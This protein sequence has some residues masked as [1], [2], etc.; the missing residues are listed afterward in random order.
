MHPLIARRND[1]LRLVKPYLNQIAE[2][3]SFVLGVD[4]SALAKPQ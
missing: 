4:Y 3:I 1:M 2:E